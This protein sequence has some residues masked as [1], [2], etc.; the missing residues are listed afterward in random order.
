MEP[1]KLNRSKPKMISFLGCIRLLSQPYTGAIT[2]I[3][4]VGSVT[5]ICIIP[6]DT[7]G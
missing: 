3:A 2:Q 1:P 4:S 5:I 6:I 7:F